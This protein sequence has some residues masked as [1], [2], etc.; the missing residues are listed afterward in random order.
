MDT[1][2]DKG[3]AAGLMPIWF[4]FGQI[5]L[6]KDLEQTKLDARNHSGVESWLQTFQMK[7]EKLETVMIAVRFTQ[8]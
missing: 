4:R 6:M 3:R 2:R 1:I 7:K 8:V 5:N